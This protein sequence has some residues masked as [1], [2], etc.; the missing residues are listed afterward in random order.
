[1][2]AFVWS[3]GT[4]AAVTH[5]ARHGV[6]VCAR[7]VVM[8]AAPEDDEQEPK[9]YIARPSRYPDPAMNRSYYDPLAP[10]PGPKKFS[11]ASV[12]Q[13]H[14]SFQDAWYVKNGRKVDVWV[15]IGALTILTPVLGLLIGALTG[16]IPGL[17]PS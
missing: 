17:F 1:M 7:R 9:N 3:V 16:A 4:G 13:Q 14:M 8:Q 10:T 6:R 12:D 11:Q 2:A 15:V 5:G